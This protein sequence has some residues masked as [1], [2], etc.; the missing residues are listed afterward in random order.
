MDLS[1]FQKIL[2]DSNSSGQGERNK[3]PMRVGYHNRLAVVRYQFPASQTGGVVSF[4]ASKSNAVLKM[5]IDIFDL[6]CAE[7]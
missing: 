4:S 1:L 6:F 3:Y 7:R 5:L 2:K